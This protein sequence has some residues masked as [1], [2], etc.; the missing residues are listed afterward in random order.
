M[1]LLQYECPKKSQL[2]IDMFK[3]L[4]AVFT[5]C[6][7]LLLTVSASADDLTWH[8]KSFLNGHTINIKAIDADGNEHDVKAIR[9]VSDSQVMS[10]QARVNDS[11]LPIKL[12]DQGND[13]LSVKAIAEDGTLL[14]I[15]G[16]DDNDTL[17]IKGV[18][19]SGVVVH[20]KAVEA[21]GSQHGVKAIGP[22]GRTY[23][24]KGLRFSDGME[25]TI[26]GV[27]FHG[28]IKAI[29]PGV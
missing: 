23:D 16:I 19:Q 7:A 29:P 4:C 8:V 2:R 18:A 11:V 15:K 22:D 5:M 13:F 17:D 12:I 3:N 9:Q 20:I 21:D 1:N 27:E 14:D 6:V 28:H 10:I 24:V 26:N 25:G